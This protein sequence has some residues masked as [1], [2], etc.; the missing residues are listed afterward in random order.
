MERVFILPKAPTA[1]QRQRA[2]A[3]RA[4]GSLASTSSARLAILSMYCASSSPMRSTRRSARALRRS[5]GCGAPMRV[6]GFP[7]AFSMLCRIASC[8]KP[9]ESVMQTPLRPARPVRPLRW[10]YVSTSATPER[11]AGGSR[12]MTSVI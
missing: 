6:K 8:A 11:V 7:T 5:D 3:S 1:R 4:S 12:L 9:V 10:M 2:M